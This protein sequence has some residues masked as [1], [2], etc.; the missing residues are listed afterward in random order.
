MDRCSPRGS[1]HTHSHQVGLQLAGEAS[2]G[3]L[4]RRAEGFR[5]PN[6]NPRARRN[7]DPVTLH[8]CRGMSGGDIANPVQQDT[9]SEYVDHD[10]DQNLNDGCFHTTTSLHQI[11]QT[12][13]RYSTG[14][15]EL[16]CRSL[17]D[18]SW[19]SAS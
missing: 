3:T 7:R 4:I 13:L 10:A 19:V 12:G 14:N 16:R 8:G 5:E 17:S 1:Y 2:A 9:E 11:R 18:S 6:E 15:V